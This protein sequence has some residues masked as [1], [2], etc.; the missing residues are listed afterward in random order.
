M[1][2]L[3]DYVT[4][5][6]ME[7]VQT[8]RWGTYPPLGGKPLRK[9]AIFTCMDCRLA[10]FILPALG[11]QRGDAKVIKNAGTLFLD[12]E[13]DSVIISLAVAIFL[14]EVEEILVIGHYDCG[15]SQ[16]NVD[17]FIERMRN[18]GVPE[19][20]I[21]TARLK[22]QPWAENAANLVDSVIGTCSRIVSSPLIPQGI[23]VH[24]LL[25]H[26]LTGMI[27]VVVNGYL[28]EK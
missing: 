19:Q 12:N 3:L 18:R 20:A 1:T 11:L 2:K 22:L 17:D 14:L 25:I 28:Q 16:L 6:N 23:P 7:F 10:E 5:A 15:V 4:R 27:Q 26:P 9:V 21:E 8:G 24:G 13:N